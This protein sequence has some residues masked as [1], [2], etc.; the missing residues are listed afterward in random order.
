MVDVRDGGSWNP[1]F[2][3]QLNDW[4]FEEVDNFFKRFHDHSSPLDFE[5][6]LVWVD[7]KNDV[8]FVKS[9][10]FS[11]DSRGGDHFPY[12]MVWNLW[13][14]VGVNLF[15]RQLGPGFWHRF[16]SEKGVVKCLI[17]GTCVKNK[18]K[19]VIVFFCI[20]RK[21]AFCDRW[22]LLYLMYIGWWIL[23]WKGCFWVG[24]APLLVE[25]GKR[26]GKLLIYV[27]F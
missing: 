14:L 25:K 22:F 5:D 13:A 12:S 11:L 1:R 24:D 9:F 17:D 21:L 19:W 18:E 2:F 26:L 10:Y 4:E 6:I 27:I 8:F 20:V 3:K 16:S 23:W 7:T 15:G